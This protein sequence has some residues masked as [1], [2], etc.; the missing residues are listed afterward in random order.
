MFRR[1]FRHQDRQNMHMRHMHQ[2]HRM[3]HMMHMTQKY[4]ISRFGRSWC[5]ND[6]LDLSNPTSQS[7]SGLKM[8]KKEKN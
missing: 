1:S 2:M 6:R 5:L 3:R 8:Y 4:V 7:N